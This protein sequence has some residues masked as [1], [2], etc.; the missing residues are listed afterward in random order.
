MYGM[1]PST[2]PVMLVKAYPVG[3]RCRG[4]GVSYNIDYSL[5]SAPIPALTVWLINKFNNPFV[6]YWFL[7]ISFII[8][9]VGI[10]LIKE[11]VD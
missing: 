7:L 11:T 8:T 9:L 2:Y 10:A 3:F 1:L 4:V 5:F 6:P